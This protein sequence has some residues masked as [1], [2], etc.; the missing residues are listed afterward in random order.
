[1]LRTATARQPRA[2]SV[3]LL[4]PRPARL[5]GRE[6]ANS[7]QEAR[8]RSQAVD[9]PQRRHQRVC[10]GQRPF[11]ARSNDNQI[12]PELRC[13]LPLVLLA[14]LLNL[15]LCR[16]A[17]D[18]YGYVT[19]KEATQAGVPAV[20]LPKLAARGAWRTSPTG[21]I[22]YPTRR[23]LPTTSTPRCSWG[24]ARAL[25]LH[26]ESVLALFGLADVN[27]RQIKVAVPSL[28]K[29]GKPGTC[30]PMRHTPPGW[31]LTVTSKGRPV[32]LDAICTLPIPCRLAK[33]TPKVLTPIERGSAI[34]AVGFDESCGCDARVRCCSILASRGHR[35][36]VT[37]GSDAPAGAPRRA[38]CRSSP[39]TLM[40]WHSAGAP[41]LG[42]RGEGRHLRPVRRS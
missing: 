19:T 22:G 8:T 12:A 18:H 37:R 1:M 40:R 15:R 4:H 13:R 20:K 16:S 30:P 29:A 41:R 39:P 14:Q 6:S 36:T 32:G 34:A 27:P 42:R 3:L 38:A 5:L 9:G 21:C 7:P 31:P 17:F 35:L 26:G 33:P 11:S 28:T 2:S 25:Y 10:A 24:W 23:P